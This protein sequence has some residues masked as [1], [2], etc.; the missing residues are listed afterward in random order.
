MAH[1]Q[2][3]VAMNCGCVHLCDSIIVWSGCFLI[4]IG[5]VVK[6]SESQLPQQSV[7]LV[8][9]IYE[10]C[11][12]SA[13]KAPRP[14]KPKI[15]KQKSSKNFHCKGPANGCPGTTALNLE[16]SCLQLSFFAYSGVWEFFCLQL[17][18]FYLQFELF[19]FQ[20]RLFHLQW[21]SVST[22]HLSEL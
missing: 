20:W 11:A 12:Q 9:E 22:K 2:K 15:W 7:W 19:C 18:C 10:Q 6:N 21:E 14:S 16:V 4:P 5:N 8:S 3:H 1:P 17:E 13:L